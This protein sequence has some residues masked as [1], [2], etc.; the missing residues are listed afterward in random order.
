MNYHID[1]PK[2]KL[3]T[4]SLLSVATSANR[5]GRL[6]NRRARKDAETLRVRRARM[7]KVA[8]EIVKR[9][10]APALAPEAT[11]QIRI[12]D[13]RRTSGVARRAVKTS[14]RAANRAST[15]KRLAQ[16]GIES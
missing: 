16:K 1:L 2:P 11:K 8:A 14:T 10:D 12:A 3:L 5:I 4:Y 13:R 7:L 9:G 6:A 15:I